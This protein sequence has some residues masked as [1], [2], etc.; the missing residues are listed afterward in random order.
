M[1]SGSTQAS[2]LCLIQMAAGLKASSRFDYG[3]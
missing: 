3:M 2:D 1:C